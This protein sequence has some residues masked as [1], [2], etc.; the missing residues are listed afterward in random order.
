MLEVAVRPDPH[1]AIVGHAV[2]GVELQAGRPRIV[3]D[4]PERNM[5]A[6]RADLSTATDSHFTGFDA[7]VEVGEV[8]VEGIGDSFFRRRHAVC[9]VTRAPAAASGGSDLEVD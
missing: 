2:G 1:V 7:D 3:G 6:S 9:H 4:D 8:A 5:P